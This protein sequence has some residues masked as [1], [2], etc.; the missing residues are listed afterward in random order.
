MIHMH[1]L[2]TLSNTAYHVRLILISTSLEI[3]I[4]SRWHVGILQNSHEASL[5]T[6]AL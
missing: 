2:V 1:H 3:P 6:S 4:T 5:S